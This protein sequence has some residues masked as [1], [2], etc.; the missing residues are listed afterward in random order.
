MRSRSTIKQQ[1]GDKAE[2][3]ACEFLEKQNLLLV[4]RNYRC[5]AG[6]IDLIMRDRDVWVFVEV[7]YRKSA[8]F[9]TAIESVN[10]AK[11]QRLIRAANYYLQGA[12]LAEKVPCRFDIVALQSSLRESISTAVQSCNLKCEGDIKIEWVKN[13]FTE[14]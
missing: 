11:Q 7:R 8:T 3:L 9:G 4:T 5:R 14:Q 12:R 2:R 1:W 10:Y 6:E 13:A